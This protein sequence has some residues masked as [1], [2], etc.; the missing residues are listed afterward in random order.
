[1]KSG[2]NKFEDVA[3]LAAEKAGKI[4]K[5]NFG[6]VKKV[7]SKGESQLVSNVDL[8]AEEVIIKTIKKYFP[9]HSILS[10]ENSRLKDSPHR[11]IIDPLDGTHN[12]IKGI[13]I[14]GVSIA[15]EYK[16]EVIV[17]VLYFPLDK[18]LYWAE[19]GKGA[20]LNERK[21]QVSSRSLSEVTCVY[22][23]SIRLNPKEMLLVLDNL[24]KRVF[25]LRMFGSSAEHLA[26]I[27]EGKIDLDIEFNDKSWD[28]A[29]GAL[30]VKEAGGKFTDFQGRPWNADISNYVASNGLIHQ[31]VLQ[32]IKESL[33]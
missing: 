22:D 26:M 24:A 12:F 18:R 20:Y 16:K 19:K 13:P 2:L 29:A 9:A 3:V 7:S 11:W 17:G 6:K 33:R 1:M 23:S 15:L 30:I 28:F 27:A 32:I 21:L 10:E 14:F 8:E 25:N 5:E 4:L 31:E